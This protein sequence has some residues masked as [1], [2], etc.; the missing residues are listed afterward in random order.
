MEQIDTAIIIENIDDDNPND[1]D[2]EPTT[3]EDDKATISDPHTTPM[4]P[5][6]TNV[7]LSILYISTLE[8]FDTFKYDLHV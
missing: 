5:H 8:Q 3:T 2:D 7:N 4:Q 1:E 6:R